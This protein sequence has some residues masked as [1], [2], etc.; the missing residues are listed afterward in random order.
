VTGWDSY[1]VRR[2]EADEALSFSCHV[3]WLGV[4]RRIKVFRRRNSQVKDE[5]YATAGFGSENTGQP[6]Q[7]THPQS[8]RLQYGSGLQKLA[9]QRRKAC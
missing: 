5:I 6:A 8:T 2:F 7:L 9:L 1:L 4:V 3:D